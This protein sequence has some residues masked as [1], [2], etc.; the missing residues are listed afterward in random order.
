M[1]N[2]GHTLEGMRYIREWYE[3]GMIGEVREV[4]AWTN[5]STPNN[6]N[7]KIASCPTERDPRHAWTGTCGR[8]R[9]R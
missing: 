8:G 9:L 5:R 2:Q 7:A 1:G 4:H 3:A 6:A